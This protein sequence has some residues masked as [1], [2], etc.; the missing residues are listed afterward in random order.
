MIA[1][2]P[3]WRYFQ[4]PSDRR[5]ERSL[6]ELDGWIVE[7]IR[8]TRDRMKAHPELAEDPE[9]L[10]QAML[11]GE[12][13]D[14]QP[15]SDADV[16]GNVM[17]M[18]LA[19]EDTTARTLS[20][21]V[22]ELLEHPDVLAAVKAEVDSALTGGS[23]PE[24]MSALDQ[25]KLTSWSANEALRLRAVVPAMAS[26]T[27]KETVVDGVRLTPGTHVT[28]MLRRLSTSPDFISHPKQFLPSRWGEEGLAEELRGRGIYVP[29]GSGP[30]ICPGRALAL[31]EIR[32]VLGMLLRDFELERVGRSED[33]K[34][35][36]SFTMAPRGLR[37]RL[38]PR[39]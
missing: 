20:W 11:T 38:H 27:L 13:S 12:R 7:L 35:H 9:N 6:N 21:T 31:L 33:V 17:T 1:V 34:E 37:V 36:L 18:L 39:T 10:L 14:G 32:L 4:L 5:L 25:L 29:F 2:F 23:I 16:A 30:R 19:G 8:E 3:Y 24:E 26:T 28:L 15:F 22:H